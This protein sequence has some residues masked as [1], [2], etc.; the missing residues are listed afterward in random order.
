MNTTLSTCL[1]RLFNMKIEIATL[2]VG[3]LNANCHLVYSS[4][5]E[6]ALVVDPGG[7]FLIIKEK[8]KELN[9]RAG[10]VILT[11]GHFDHIMA[12]ADFSNEGVK[13]YMHENDLPLL[14]SNGNLAK[15]WGVK[16]P[17][18]SVDNALIGGLFEICGFK[19]EVIETPGHTAGS[20]CLRIDN[21]LLTGDCL[22]KCGF[23]RVDFPSGNA[24]DLVNSIKKLF[25]IGEDLVVYSGHGEN[26]TLNYERQFNPINQ[27]F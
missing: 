14:T 6:E 7:D 2:Q 26:T 18:F 10:A 24:K 12:S 17:A 25:D 27:T 1:G 4:E 11:H 16:L 22:F 13:I 8:L 9:K 3:P 23:G 20:I 5:R 21:C 15:Y 19:I